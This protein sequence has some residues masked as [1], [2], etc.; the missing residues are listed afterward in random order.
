LD[1]LDE[2]DHLN[3]ELN[4]NVFQSS[5]IDNSPVT[6]FMLGSHGT[7]ASGDL[8]ETARRM[9][10]GG[11][12]AIHEMLAREG[13]LQ[14]RR[15]AL[16]RQMHH[17]LVAHGCDYTVAMESDDY[18]LGIDDGPEVVESPKRPKT[19]PRAKTRRDG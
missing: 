9:I 12:N 5:C 4:D 16:L 17:T 8:V 18:D 7:E 15:V 2:L 11:F 13:R 3:Q 19:V 1:W 6:A 10:D 14:E